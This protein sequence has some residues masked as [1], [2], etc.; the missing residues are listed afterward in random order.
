MAQTP[1]TS[2]PT[3]LVVDD[4]ENISYLVS[5]ALRLA[6]LTVEAAATG[7]EALELAARVRPQVVVLDVMLPDL[8][9]FEVLRRL[10]AG[11]CLA[12][13]LFLTARGDTADRVRGLTSGGDDY[14]T[15][16]FA[17]EEL[18]ARV[19]V[20]LR[21]AGTQAA[22]TARHQVHDLVLDEDQHR[23]WRG[24]T[25]VH[26]T[27]TEFSLLRI[28][29]TNA[30]RVVT[31]AQILDHVWQYDFAGETAIIESFVSTLRKK[32]DG[33][34]PKLIHTVRGVGYTVREPG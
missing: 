5:S 17:L 10:R 6:G 33:V 2:S 27:A 11:G 16:P 21:R 32:V 18:V 30:G 24:E 25:E 15:K 13:V 12:P 1:G 23:V 22:P 28:L 20:A 3:V 31:R 19:H 29:L 14:I 4:E 9:G 7:G 34:E 26:L 8:D